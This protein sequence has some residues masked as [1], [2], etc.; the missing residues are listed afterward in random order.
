M[1]TKNKEKEEDKKKRENL[2]QIISNDYRIK[3]NNI[4]DAEEISFNNTFKNVT[5][6]LYGFVNNNQNKKQ[7]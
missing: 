1:E 5:Y 6:D 7:S 2:N 3:R 4:L